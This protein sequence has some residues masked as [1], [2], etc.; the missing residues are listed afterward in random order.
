MLEKYLIHISMVVLGKHFFQVSHRLLSNAY[1]ETLLF[2]S[3][4]F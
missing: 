3:A 1:I 2:L 4:V